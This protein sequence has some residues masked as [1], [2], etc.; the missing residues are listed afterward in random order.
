MMFFNFLWFVFS[1]Q[2]RAL[3]IVLDPG[4]GGKS[5]GCAYRYD[6]K[7]F[8]ER[9]LNHKMAQMLKKELSR[10]KTKD[11]GKIGVYVTCK[12]NQNPSLYERVQ[13]GKKHN[14][15]LFLSMHLNASTDRR[16]KGAMVLVTHSHY[17]P[18]S[19]QN[20]KNKKRKNDLYAREEKLA[21]TI[22]RN[23][24][25]Q[26]VS[27]PR[28][29][30]SSQAE[31]KGGL[32]RRPSDDG[33][34]YPNGDA[35]DWYGIVR[36]GVRNGILA[37]LVEH[38]HLSNSDDYYNFLSSDEKLQKLVRADALSIAQYYGLVLKK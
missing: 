2:T 15:D 9:D 23:L 38:A 37:V 7:E 19:G 13:F 32:L 12:R 17:E 30:K 5:P 22:I 3:N 24:N 26:G 4:H 29:V 18:N 21:K 28:D 20:G 11:N 8:I 36:N 35:S 34:K 16:R 14:A 27:I 6:G 33:D 25:N 10:Y 1:S 31:L